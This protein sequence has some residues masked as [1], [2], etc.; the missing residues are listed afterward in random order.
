MLLRPFSLPSS[1]SLTIDRILE[2]GAI[3]QDSSLHHS[4]RNK[5]IEG[6]LKEEPGKI[7]AMG[8]QRQKVCQFPRRQSLRDDAPAISLIVAI[9]AR[10]KDKNGQSNHN[11]DGAQIR[12]HELILYVRIVGDDES[13]GHTLLGRHG[14]R[15]LLFNDR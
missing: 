7:D 1:S 11:A 5:E 8:F 12:A 10:Q 2:A 9:V 6:H 14:R 15:R 3:S 13:W 4:T